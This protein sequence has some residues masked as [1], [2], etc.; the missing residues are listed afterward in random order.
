LTTLLLIL[1]LYRKTYVTVTHF[2]N[3]IAAIMIWRW[4]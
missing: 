4:T 3:N 2:N 1:H